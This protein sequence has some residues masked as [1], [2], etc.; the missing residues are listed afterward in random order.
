MAGTCS[1]D[2]RDEKH[3]IL[4][5]KHEGKRPHGRSRSR[6]KDSIGIDFKEKGWEV[7]PEFIWLR[8]RLL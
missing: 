6:R 3:K 1:T 2:G 7:R 5:G 4:I 8:D